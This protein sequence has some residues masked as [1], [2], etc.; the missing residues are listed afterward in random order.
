MIGRLRL[1]S[2]FAGAAHP[3]GQSLTGSVPLRTGQPGRLPRSA[4]GRQMAA[5]Q[6]ISTSNGPCQAETQTKLRAGGSDG[7]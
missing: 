7:K 6:S 5:T 4:R 3:D 1:F 2:L